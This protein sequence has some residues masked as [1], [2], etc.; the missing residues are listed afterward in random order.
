[1]E[2]ARPIS[3]EIMRLGAFLNQYYSPDG[4]FSVGNMLEQAEQMD[5]WGFDTATLGERHV[6][7]EGFVEPITGLAAIAARTTL[8]VGTAAVLPAIYDP[9]HLA[10]QVATIDDIASGTVHFG[11]ALGYREREFE[12]FGVD[13]DERVGRFV[14]ALSLL[15]R[16]WQS[17]GAVTHHGDFYHYDDVFVSPLPN[18]DIP[19]WIGGHADV[20]IERAAYRGNGWIA[21]ASSSRERLRAQIDTYECALDDFGKDRDENEVV[22]MREC[23]VADSEE[24]A[25]DAIEPYL[26]NLYRWYERWGQAYLAGEDTRDE[27]DRLKEKFVVGT[28]ND[29]IE[30]LRTYEEMG[31]DHILLRWQ[32]P[33]Q[34][35]ESALACIDRLG[36]AVIPEFR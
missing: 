16:L 9:L 13:R 32:F 20:A 23:F 21:S 11:A 30:D 8:D 6:H 33:G 35:Q 26:L 24:A 1:M 28:P 15:R 10:E 34:S 5:E 14:E 12:A 36:E 27:W 25:R 17:P 7:E 3:G 29:V 2:R 19:I 31:V 18:S 4:G 22:L